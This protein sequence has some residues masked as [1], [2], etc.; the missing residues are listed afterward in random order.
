M[1]LFSFAVKRCCIPHNKMSL[2]C[3]ILHLALQG[4]TNGQ[5]ER[6]TGRQ[7]VKRLRETV[8]CIKTMQVEFITLF[9]AFKFKE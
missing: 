8:N 3:G 7:A 9:T 4:Q 5:A 6:Q 1:H 2:S